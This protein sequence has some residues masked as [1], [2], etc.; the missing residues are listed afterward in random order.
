[1]NKNYARLRAIAY[2]R[3]R[4]RRQ[5]HPSQ[6]W[7]LYLGLGFLAVVIL[8]PLLVFT[9]TTLAAAGSAFVVY[10]RYAAE[11]RD[12]IEKVSSV[13]DR[14]L[15]QS[16]R[17]YD[18]NGVLLYE[19]VDQGRR[20]PVSLDDMPK[21][22]IDATVATEDDTFWDNPGFDP[23][24][25]VRAVGQNLMGGRT[26]S[27][28]STITQ[29]LVRHV[30]FPYEER[31][32]QSYD[33]KVKEIVL[34][35]VM[36]QRMGK[37]EILQTYLNEIYYGNLS[38]GIEAAAKTFFGK[39]A[40][41]LTTAEAAFLAGLPQSPLD[42]DP[43]SPSGFER[44]RARQKVV[45]G[46]MARH[47]YLTD[48]EADD[49]YNQGINL[50]PEDQR[51]VS[52]L[53]PHFVNYIRRELEDRYGPDKVNRGGLQVYTTLDIRMQSLAEE[54]AR[55]RV[56]ELKPQ[57]VTNSALVALKNDTGEILAM[58]GSVDYWDNS[59]DGRVNV[60]VRERQPGSSMKPITYSAALERGISPAEILWDVPMKEKMA[61]GTYYEPHNYDEKWHGPVRMRDALANSYNIPAVKMIKQ[62]G[63][64]ETIDAAHRLG[65]TGLDRGPQWYGL[66]LTLGGGEV[67]LL[68]MTTAYSTLAR[69][70]QYMSPSGLLK[71]VDGDKNVLYE[72]K[73]PQPQLV[74]N[75]AA[76]YI[77]T[78]YL[79]DENARIPAFGPNSALKLSQPAA[80]KTGTT[81][82]YRDNWTL[83]YTPY[84]TVGVWAGNSD[85]SPMIKSSGVTGAAPI[86]HDFFEAVFASPE[87]LEV[88]RPSPGAPL[89]QTFDR[90]A[91]V[92][93]ANICA[94]GPTCG[95]QIKEL[96]IKGTEPK[97]PSDGWQSVKAI[98]IETTAQTD[99]GP[100]KKTLM[101]AAPD[102][103]SDGVSQVNLL[104]MP[105]DPEEA[106]QAT[107]WLE[108]SKW[109]SGQLQPCTDQ[110]LALAH[111]GVD[112]SNPEAV[113]AAGLTLTSTDA[114]NGGSRASG[115]QGGGM[116]L[117]QAPVAGIAAP[118]NDGVVTGVVPVTGRAQFNPSEVQFYKVEYRPIGGDWITI[119]DTHKKPTSGTLETWHTEALA[120]GVYQLRLA[121]V[122][123]DGNFMVPSQV[124]V[125]VE[126]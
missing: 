76:T 114:A 88:L 91:D 71:V 54:V 119:G 48:K 111:A 58:L 46:L 77:V 44:A 38:Y 107:T 112:P 63:V 82:D 10:N 51:Q 2:S 7:W 70:G 4:E 73:P 28:A 72:F 9:A 115:S 80:V 81:N 116:A 68:D 66:S 101:C 122:K 110:W 53:A 3:R 45:L 120:P 26:L 64:Q 41:D 124:T 67:T 11:V 105:K 108:S 89:K 102:G 65:I 61:D 118:A 40:K 87:L 74:M 36:T 52:L 39:P 126:K 19:I 12:G 75:P 93:E 32:S 98:S 94:I 92:V 20:T 49:I 125:R 13:R 6:P 104:T 84:M 55:R 21:A 90:P 99:K 50:V 8:V 78:N 83:G 62:V 59:I 42:L 18:R 123:A 97:N 95:K 103:M 79:S 121:L 17:I 60:S 117:Q 35:W 34:A 33:R 16:T 29:Q 106:K 86:W 85:N 47:G 24:S 113:A 22:L 43:F 1:M 15:F 27:G 23:I 109:P 14:D 57:N 31:V 37:R 30:A 69:E 56:A 96:F 25:L 5:T 100:E